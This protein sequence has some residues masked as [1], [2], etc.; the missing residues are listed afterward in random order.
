MRKSKKK[1]AS[2]SQPDGDHMT[3][4]V[5]LR[6]CSRQKLH[7]N[8]FRFDVDEFIYEGRYWFIQLIISILINIEGIL[9][10]LQG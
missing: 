8:I 2:A 4:Q 9:S 3:F 6:V 10:N 7:S 1:K 5:Y